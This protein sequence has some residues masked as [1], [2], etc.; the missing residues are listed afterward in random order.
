[1]KHYKP[2]I[3]LFLRHKANYSSPGPSH[4]FVFKSDRKSSS[5]EVTHFHKPAGYV[6]YIAME[7]LIQEFPED[8]S[9]VEGEGVVFKVKV[10]AHPNPLF[11][12]LHNDREVKSDYS[13]DVNPSDGTLTFPS[14][15]R[16]HSGTYKLVVKNDEGHIEREVKLIVLT[17]WENPVISG[18]S[19]LKSSPVPVA[20]FGKYVSNLHSNSNAGFKEQYQV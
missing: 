10:K 4:P 13:R 2:S 5:P 7:T 12:W 11:V 14:V 17:E 8:T 18:E 19:A 16:R 6:G 9:A 20:D 3:Y 15:E 1:M